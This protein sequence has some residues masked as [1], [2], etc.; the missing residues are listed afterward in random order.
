ML[1]VLGEFI[2]SY[3]GLCSRNFSHII[4]STNHV[5]I[6]MFIVELDRGGGNLMQEGRGIH[7]MMVL[8]ME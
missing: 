4:S 5:Q 1:R 8:K 2:L 3:C 7:L 6:G